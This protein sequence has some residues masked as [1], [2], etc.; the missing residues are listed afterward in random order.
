MA[1]M[2]ATIIYESFLSYVD[3]PSSS[4]YCRLYDLGE[5]SSAS[6]LLFTSFLLP[7]AGYVFS[8]LR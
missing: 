4:S 2:M 3:E 1:G 5:R 7:F 6:Y 8:T